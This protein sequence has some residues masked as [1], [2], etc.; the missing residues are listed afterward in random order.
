MKPKHGQLGKVWE[1]TEDDYRECCGVWDEDT[2]R[3]CVDPNILKCFDSRC[4]FDDVHE[5]MTRLEPIPEQC[6]PVTVEIKKKEHYAD[7]TAFP[8]MAA[9]LW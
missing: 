1:P 2:Y 5:H 3:S 9:T 6:I 7:N 8:L 4:D